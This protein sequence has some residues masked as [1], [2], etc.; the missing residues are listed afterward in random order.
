MNPTILFLFNVN[1]FSKPNPLLISKSCPNLLIPKAP[2]IPFFVSFYAS[3]FVSLFLCFIVSFLLSFFP[4]SLPS[5][6]FSVPRFHLYPSHPSAVGT[7]TTVSCWHFKFR[8]LNPLS[9]PPP[10]GLHFLLAPCMNGGVSVN[11]SPCAGPERGLW[12]RC[13]VV[14]AGVRAV[15]VD[16]EEAGEDGKVRGRWGMRDTGGGRAEEKGRTVA[17]TEFWGGSQAE[18]G[19]DFHLESG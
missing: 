16:G 9:I 14:T 5:F 13:E 19:G 1:K 7:P 4:P 6:L 8:A 10:K 18:V 3:F 12:G 2:A 17:K 11:D 15:D